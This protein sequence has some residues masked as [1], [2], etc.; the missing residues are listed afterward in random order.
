MTSALR[1]ARLRREYS[2]LYPG[3][4]AGVWEVA[5]NLAERLQRRR[6]WRGTA[7]PGARPL[8]DAHFEFRGGRMGAS[9]TDRRRRWTDRPADN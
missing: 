6:E 8:N 3:I 7:A 2:H 4:P 9:R 1:Q 5:A